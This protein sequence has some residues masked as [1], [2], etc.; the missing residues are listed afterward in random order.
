MKTREEVEMLRKKYPK[1]TRI[2]LQEMKDPQAVPS[3][4]IGTVEHVDDAGTIHMHWLNGSGLGLIEGEDMFSVMETK[5]NYKT[6]GKT[7]CIFDTNLISTTE[8][9]KLEQVS[10]KDIVTLSDEDFIFFKNNLNEDYNFIREFRENLV[11]SHEDLSCLLIKGESNKDGIIIRSKSSNMAEYYSYI[12]HVEDLMGR[13][14]HELKEEMQYTSAQ[15]HRKDSQ[16]LKRRCKIEKII[17]LTKEDY[18]RFADNLLQDYGFIK[19]NTESMYV[20]N[21]GISHCILVIGEDE[22]DGILV[23]SEGADYARYTALLPNAK[24]FMRQ[25]KLTSLIEDV[26]DMMKE[27]RI[28]V[29]IVKPNEVPFEMIID[30]TLEAKQ[31]IVGGYIEAVPLSESAE[32]IC[33]D[34]GKLIGLPPN[35][36]LGNDIITGTFIIVGANESEHFCSLSNEDIE[37]Y[38]DMFK[39]I[40]ELSMED[41]PQ[42]EFKIIGFD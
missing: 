22:P 29:L 31:E 34:E 30:N 21:E 15:F 3:G 36:R 7:T 27:E 18:E 14:R 32:L 23:Q 16:V 11:G 1:G 41:I 42:P 2:R 9:L 5:F 33:N 37:K 38:K 4:T 8:R 28:R 10:I 39:E 19:E 35:R 40:E 26:D 12:P 20:D 6:E 25:N 13:L 17:S 24:Q